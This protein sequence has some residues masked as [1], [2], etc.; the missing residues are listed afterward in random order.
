MIL[1]KKKNLS[2]AEDYTLCQVFVYIKNCLQKEWIFGIQ[3]CIQNNNSVFT[4]LSSYLFM[5]MMTCVSI[6]L[7]IAKSFSVKHFVKYFLVYRQPLE[8]LLNIILIKDMIF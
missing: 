5:M 1:K 6:C 7:Q 2:L 3:I 8:L 4:F